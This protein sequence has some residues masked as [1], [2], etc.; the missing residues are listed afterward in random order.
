MTDTVTNDKIHLSVVIRTRN[1]AES[2]QNLFEALAAQRCSFNWELVVVDNDSE[3]ETRSLCTQYNARVISISRAEFTAG[4]AL[5][6][7]I[8]HARGELVLLCSPHSIPVGSGFL[9]NAVV[10]FPTPKRGWVGSFPATNKEQMVRWYRPQDIQYN[11]TS[12]QE[13]AESGINWLS[14]YPSATCCVIRR[15]LWEKI[16]YDEYLESIED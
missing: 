7:G 2:L 8:T 10:P 3:D 13:S 5:N 6:L 1:S 12:E 9:E 16:P 15:S 11:S 4:R 14:L